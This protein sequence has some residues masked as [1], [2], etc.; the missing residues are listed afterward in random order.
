MTEKVFVDDLVNN[1]HLSIYYGKDYLDRQITTSDISRP[2]LELTGYFNY[3][4]ARRIQLL[5]I[6]ETSY[7]KG[8][9][10]ADLYDVMQKKCVSQKR[11]HL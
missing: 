10:T 3:Y 2:G 1:T 4:P 7:A 11:Q 6:T 5:G 9:S 8:M